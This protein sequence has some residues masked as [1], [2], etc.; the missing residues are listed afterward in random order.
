MKSNTWNNS[1]FDR[2]NN[3]VGWASPTKSAFYL[4]L[5]LSFSFFN[6][7]VAIM[8]EYDCNKSLRFCRQLLLRPQANTFRVS[9][10][11]VESPQTYW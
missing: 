5:T 11:I 2:R 7:F 3:P 6:C 10:G 4:D 1:S 9:I 8:V